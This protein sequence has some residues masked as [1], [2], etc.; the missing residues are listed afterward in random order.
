[1]SSYALVLVTLAG[2]LAATS[3]LDVRREETEKLYNCPFLS[4]DSGSFLF[5][6]EHVYFTSMGDLF[7]LN[8]AS[9]DSGSE[10]RKPRKVYD[11]YFAKSSSGPL[12][13]RNNDIYFMSKGDLIRYDETSDKSERVYECFDSDCDSGSFLQVG[14][15]ELF[16]T[17]G[18]DLMFYDL[19]RRGKVETRARA[20]FSE[21]SSGSINQIGRMLYYMSCG[22]VF[23]YELPESTGPASEETTQV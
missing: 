22:D 14:E 9:A 8:L 5:E 18:G 19:A 13:R 3:A 2:F 23:R 15:N 7:Y 4:C 1:M 12:F 16:F 11:A 20:A 17:S 6:G 21:C 10:E